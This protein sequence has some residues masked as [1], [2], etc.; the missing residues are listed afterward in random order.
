[1]HYLYILYSTQ[2]DKYYTGETA[3]L[4]SRLT[5]HNTHHFMKNYTKA[6]TD[7]TLKHQFATN[8]KEEAVYLEKFIK[9]MKSRIF[10]EKIIND[11]VILKQILEDKL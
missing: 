7:W 5:Q 9:R 11:P 3:N 1:M 6:A 8:I 2:A 10:I 4:G